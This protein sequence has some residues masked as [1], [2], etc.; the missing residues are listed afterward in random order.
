VAA[1]IEI[2]GKSVKSSMPFLVERPRREGAEEVVVILKR[3]GADQQSSIFCFK[4]VQRFG[5]DHPVYF[6][7]TCLMYFRSFING[8]EFD[9]I[10]AFL[11]PAG[12]S[13]LRASNEDALGLYYYLCPSLFQ[14]S[15]S[16]SVYYSGELSIA[17]NR[18]RD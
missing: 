1:E 8:E 5:F 6:A 14:F 7:R 13:R 12:S 10:A 18:G 2:G 9:L 17:A 11:A 16:R 15:F 3:A 4:K